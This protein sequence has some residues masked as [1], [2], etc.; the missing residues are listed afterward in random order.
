M[1]IQ[2]DQA[3]RRRRVSR[4]VARA[5]LA[6]FPLC[7]AAAQ[8]QQPQ[9]GTIAGQV[10][11]V[12]DQ[13]PIPGVVVRLDGTTRGAITGEDG[14]YLIH[15]V[16]AGTAA[17]IAQRTGYATA[18]L[19]VTV[20]AGDTTRLDFRLEPHATVLSPTVVSA[21]REV[22][23]RDDATAAIEV[24]DG[25]EIRR[26]RS[27]HPAQLLN[28]LAGVHVSELSGEGHSMAIRQPITTKPMYLYLED[29]IP[30]RATG[31][32]NHN[33]LYEVNVPQSGGV[34]VMKGPGTAL[35]GSDAIGGV[36]NVLTRGAP[37][38]PSAEASVEGGSAGYARML[39]S[40]GTMS[41]SHGIRGDLNVTRSD[42]WRDEARYERLSGTIRWDWSGAGGLTSRTVLTASDVDQ[43]DVATI[44]QAAF[45]T[46]RT[47]NR[48]P[49]AYRSVSAVR[50]SSAVELDRGSTLWSITPFARYNT[51]E[52]IPSWQLSYDPQ[53]WDT[54][55]TSLGL[56]AKV[57][58]DLPALNS[59][60]I[61]GV[62]MD[63]SPG[64]FTAQQIVTSPS[65]GIWSSYTPGEMHYDYDVTYRAMSPYVQVEY[66]P[67]SRVT[68]E[69]GL[70]WDLVGYDYSS[71]LQPLFTGA[72]RRP[73]DTTLSWSHL[74][75]KLGITWRADDRAAFFASY[76]HGFRAPSQGQLFQQN[77]AANSVGLEPVKVDAVEAG[78]RGGFGGR[79][80]YQ[81]SAYD[82]WITDDILTFV[83]PMNTREATNA[84]S[85]RHRGVEAS[86][87]L[88]L[89]SDLRLDAAWSV[90]SQRYREWVPQA[91]RPATGTAPAV[92]EVRYDGH[93][94][95]GA[96]RDLGSVMLTW[97]PAVLRGGRVAVEWTHTG[98]YAMDPANLREYGGHDVANL[99]ASGTV[100]QGVELF[101][102]VTNLFDRRY[103]ET[104]AYDSFQ[105]AQ[106]QPG[107]GRSV[108]AGVRLDWRR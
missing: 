41:G 98:R 27:S 93:R 80:V 72:H 95:E 90:S 70:R 91:A 77:S 50:V 68:L 69:A 33:A 60:V 45:D 9:A 83:T 61:A 65:N 42:G 103:A 18:Q 56:L 13:R 24:L 21:T 26:T 78:V 89:P 67:A 1:S 28:R 31:F 38:T 11:S 6:A 102:R 105:G 62:D 25:E 79:V 85:T 88:A 96:P 40:G 39:L 48:S 43:N 84:G 52:L 76:R 54:R 10:T 46:L 63:Y 23:R 29:G 100:R 19:E 108:Y 2:R 64:S 107:A 59:R 94:M 34:E 14:R 82:M 15:P 4:L 44:G 20:S 49:I 51:L 101:G 58:H 5:V 106:Y 22:Q 87:T 7:A 37:A 35:Y 47:L 104:A 36:V 8:A 16:P 57:R 75:P 55:S 97:N 66:A 3:A 17:A 12:A 71:H 92:P 32:F 81:L 99:H 53:V 74:S 73:A 30:T 86:L